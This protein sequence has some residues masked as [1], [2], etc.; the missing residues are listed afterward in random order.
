MQVD[1]DAAGKE[2]E[3]IVRRLEDLARQ[4][5]DVQREL[6]RVA[7]AQA[8]QAVQ[9]FV[10]DDKQAQARALVHRGFRIA[11]EV[12]AWLGA[13]GYVGL[14]N[15][16]RPEFQAGYEELQAFLKPSPMA[17]HGVPR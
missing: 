15:R 13:Q 16:L 12:A 8:E 10:A 9:A 3:A 2:L 11:D 4:A 14:A 17:D 7:E 1:L 5:E 6:R